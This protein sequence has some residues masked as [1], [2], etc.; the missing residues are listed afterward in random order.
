MQIYRDLFEMWFSSFSHSCV[1]LKKEKEIERTQQ[2]VGEM[3]VQQE[4]CVVV[5]SRRRPTDIYRK[6]QCNKN[7]DDVP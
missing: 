3:N 4:T 7:D 1:I 2:R 5:G 6:T